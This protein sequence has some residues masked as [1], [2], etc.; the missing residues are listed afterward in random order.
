M[1]EWATWCPI[2]KGKKKEGKKAKEENTND[3]N[4][5]P[6]KSVGNHISFIP[7]YK[8]IVYVRIDNAKTHL[9]PIITKCV[10]KSHCH[11]KDLIIN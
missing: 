4:K 3:H 8:K 2:S 7:N 10:F 6:R 1:S 9:S 11:K 5:R